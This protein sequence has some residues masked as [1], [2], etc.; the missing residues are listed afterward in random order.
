MS[1]KEPLDVIRG[2][3]VKGGDLDAANGL[4]N[5]RLKA[6]SAWTLFTGNC[7]QPNLSA[8]AGIIL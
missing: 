1:E 6:A 8:S 4:R 3:S 7:R 5:M 2:S